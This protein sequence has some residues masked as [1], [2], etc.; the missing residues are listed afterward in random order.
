MSLESLQRE[1]NQ[2]ENEILIGLEREIL[3][4]K[5]HIEQDDHLL[6]EK[7]KELAERDIIGKF[8]YYL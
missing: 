3:N 2:K 5:K 7:L 1:I 8:N 6:D 4:L